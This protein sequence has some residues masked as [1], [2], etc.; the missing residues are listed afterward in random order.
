M[1]V[2]GLVQRRVPIKRSLAA[3][4]FCLTAPSLS[5]ELGSVLALS[6]LQLNRTAKNPMNSAAH[7][8]ASLQ[9]S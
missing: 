2:Y 8:T 9:A 4:S 3:A 6:S 7:R 5:R 1:N